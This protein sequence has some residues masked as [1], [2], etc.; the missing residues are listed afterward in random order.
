MVATINSK[1][2]RDTDLEK[3]KCPLLPSGSLGQLVA[4]MVEGVAVGYPYLLLWSYQLQLEGMPVTLVMGIFSSL[5]LV[6]SFRWK[7]P[8]TS[9]L[10]SPV[11]TCDTTA[12][13]GCSQILLLCS[14]LLR[15]PQDWRLQLC[16]YTN[17][18]CT[19]GVVGGQSFVDW[20]VSRVKEIP[21]KYL[22]TD[23]PV[24]L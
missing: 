1:D 4:M 16:T 20:F 13:T 14:V 10:V 24:G 17:A 21:T 23:L 5:G 12:A 15:G 19:Q 7:E 6:P 18:R 3:G 2:A 11:S 8:G 9:H 22:T